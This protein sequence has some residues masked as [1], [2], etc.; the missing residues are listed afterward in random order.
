MA[1]RFTPVVPVYG[2]ISLQKLREKSA[3]S[4]VYVFDD[5]TVERPHTLTI[6]STLPT[7]RKGNPG[8]V[9]TQL[10]MHK[11][12]VLDE[13]TSNERTVPLVV[14]T[15]TSFPVG[16]SQADREAVL[17]DMAGL[18]TCG[19]QG[20]KLLFNGVLPAE[21]EGIVIEDIISGKTGNA[22]RDAMVALSATYNDETYYNNDDNTAENGPNVAARLVAFAHDVNPFY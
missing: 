22:L 18:Q 12:V 4:T 17:L 13:G 10:N 14:K 5:H 2:H 16:T 7:P 19:N 3:D 15:E 9:K 21:G 8:T 20:D 1:I 6:T 11:T